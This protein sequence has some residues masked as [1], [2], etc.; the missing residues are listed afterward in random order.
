MPYFSQVPAKLV[1]VL[2][3]DTGSE[4]KCCAVQVPAKLM[5]VPVMPRLPNG[6]IDVKSLAEPEWVVVPSSNGSD[7]AGG[8]DVGAA[9]STDMEEL[10]ADIWAAEL[11]VR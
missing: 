7:A 1:S 6:K 3:R 5:S 8:G 4:L 9:P 11:K 2:E 10:L